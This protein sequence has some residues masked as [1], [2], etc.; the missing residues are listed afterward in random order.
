MTLLNC[1]LWLALIFHLEVYL[2]LKLRWWI[3]KQLIGKAPVMANL[4]VTIAEPINLPP[5]SE[6]HFWN[7][8]IIGGG[9][10]AAFEVKTP[11][12]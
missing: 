5:D 12:A 10:K 9:A 3:V 7:S 11:E 2:V 4:T 1:I 6:A 8:K